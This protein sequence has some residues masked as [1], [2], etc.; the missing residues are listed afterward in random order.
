MPAFASISLQAAAALTGRSR[1]T[2]WRRVED[3][4]LPRGEN[5]ARGRTMVRLD[6]LGADL[7]LPADDATVAEI[8]RADGGDAA[9]QNELAMR[10]LAADA[11][12]AAIYW[13]ELA[14]EQQHADAMHWLARC[15]FGGAGVA[16]DAPLGLMWLAK[17]AALGHRI[18]SEQ[19][20]RLIAS[21]VSTGLG[22]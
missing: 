1:R 9:A 2:L 11:P 5:D 4:S 21:G 6:A 20:Q 8:R 3:G 12:D 15:R 16:R 13:L 14:A 10:L 22:A 19:V 17:S 18:S 7:R